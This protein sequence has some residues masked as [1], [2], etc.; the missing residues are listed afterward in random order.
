MTLFAAKLKTLKASFLKESS[1]DARSQKGRPQKS[2]LRKENAAG[3]RP[4]RS[5][6]KT[7][8]SRRS[9]FV[10]LEQRHVLRAV[11][12]SGMTDA[13]VGEFSGFPSTQTEFFGDPWWQL[14]R[15]SPGML[16]VALDRFYAENGRA[17]GNAEEFIQSAPD[18]LLL[19]MG[20]LRPPKG[21]QKASSTSSTAKRIRGWRRSQKKKQAIASLAAWI[22]DCNALPGPD[23]C[24]RWI[25][26]VT[27]ESRLLGKSGLFRRSTAPEFHR[28]SDQKSVGNL[29][30][31]STIVRSTIDKR[32]LDRDF[33]FQLQQEKLASLKQ[34]AYG[35]SHEINNPLANIATGA[36][37]MLQDEADPNRRDR[38]G[39]IY[40]QA[41][42]AHEMISDLML[43]AH[44]PTPVK[45]SVSVRLMLKSI[46]EEA[47][48]DGI[49]L[50][51][52]L[53]PI[54]DC[55]A[56]D[57]NQMLVAIGAIL[58]NSTEAIQTRV[59]ISEGNAA[60]EAPV[61]GTTKSCCGDH[62]ADSFCPCQGKV[63]IRVDDAGPQIQFQITDNGVGLTDANVRHL[64]DPFYSGREA[65][66]G[67]GFGLSK[68]WRI[69]AMHGGQIRACAN[70]YGTGTTITFTIDK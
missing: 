42:A 66:R 43:F 67:L 40:A 36:Q 22:A 26:E 68:A 19:S 11:A 3:K 44:P 29:E 15:D 21:K 62:R 69:I 46:F 4:R 6:R 28:Q 63:A 55:V 2:R 20:N 58:K 60:C 7:Q 65:G 56:V 39:R 57:Q 70:P 47:E 18:Q 25:G 49:D 61:P 53:G 64:F 51:I 59:A 31:I 33:Q 54:V 38:L 23:E 27:G 14:F 52:T 34:L 48:R 1:Q 10:L 13:R 35:A 41:M 16:V 32:A 30:D 24:R 9:V 45:A 8:A 12:L 50:M 17:P 5:S 37:V